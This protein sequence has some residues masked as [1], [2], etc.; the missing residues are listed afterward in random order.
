MSKLAGSVSFISTSWPLMR[1]CCKERGKS[2]TDSAS[3]FSWH[4][5]TGYTHATQDSAA[6][7]METHFFSCA[8]TTLLFVSCSILFQC[9]MI[10][11]VRRHSIPWLIRLRL[12][13]DATHPCDQVGP[14]SPK[15][16]ISWL[17]WKTKSK[18]ECCSS[19]LFYI[20]KTLEC[21]SIKSR[22]TRRNPR[23]FALVH[24]LFARWW[25]TRKRHFSLP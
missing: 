12:V 18:L 11:R 20:R 8:N 13:S 6:L 14:R 16:R 10:F 4:T 24:S 9:C 23:S 19:T 21:K 25:N 2:G 22:Y 5:W 7:A 3:L 15:R 17:Q 1:S